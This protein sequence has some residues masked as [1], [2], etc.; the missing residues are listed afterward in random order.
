MLSPRV[1][2]SKSH[3]TFLIALDKLLPVPK[4]SALLLLVLRRN[5]DATA[6]R[7]R[8]QV[9]RRAITAPVL[10][11]RPELL[12]LPLATHQ[13]LDLKIVATEVAVSIPNMQIIIQRA[14]LH[15]RIRRFA[16]IVHVSWIGVLENHRV[17]GQVRDANSVLRGRVGGTTAHGAGR[18]GRCVS[19]G[20][21]HELPPGKRAIGV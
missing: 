10:L 6:R 9:N 13:R 4:L 7:V 20:N 3:L 8:A 21:A 15:A 12:A 14:H 18:Y 5:P 11:R 16:E 2:E 19:P 1:L 17:C